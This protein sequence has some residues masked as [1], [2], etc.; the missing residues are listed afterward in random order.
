MREEAGPQATATSRGAQLY[1]KKV[2][3]LYKLS[4]VIERGTKPCVFGSQPYHWPSTLKAAKVNARR[5]WKSSQTRGMTF[6]KGQ[7]R[8]S[9][10][11]TVSTTRAPATRPADSVAGWRDLRLRHGTRYHAGPSCARHTGARVPATSCLGHGRWHTPTPPP[12]R[13]DVPTDL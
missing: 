9:L 12:S 4:S 2:L 11:S 6:L 13:T 10:E 5:A 7:T 3:E 1:N 8:V